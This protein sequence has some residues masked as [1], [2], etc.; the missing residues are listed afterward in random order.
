MDRSE[1]LYLGK[2]HLSQLVNCVHLLNQPFPFFYFFYFFW[3]EGVCL[4]GSVI[5]NTYD[6]PILLFHNRQN[7]YHWK[8]TSLL[9]NSPLSVYLKN[10]PEIISKK[11]N[12]SHLMLVLGARTALGFAGWSHRNLVHRHD[13][14][15][16]QRSWCP[17]QGIP[18]VV[19][20]PLTTG[21]TTT[22]I[23]Q[24]VGRLC[25]H[26]KEGPR[27]ILWSSLSLSGPRWS[28]PDHS[29]H[30]GDEGTGS[31]SGHHGCGK[32]DLE[33]AGLKVTVR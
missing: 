33:M 17:Q 31:R 4:W 20:P 3:G 6:I 25:S 22:T 21:S 32:T 13:V 12:E 8:N 19:Y 11:R 7:T 16:Q 23:T 5:P 28:D 14:V 18:S 1:V 15:S 29:H 26:L 2:V 24:R 30:G 27:W 10:K 9:L